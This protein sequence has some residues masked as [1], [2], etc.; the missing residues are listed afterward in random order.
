MGYATKQLS[1]ICS[2]LQSL[3]EIGVVR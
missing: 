3:K 1:L 2:T